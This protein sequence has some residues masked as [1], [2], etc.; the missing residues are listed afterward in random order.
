MIAVLEAHKANLFRRQFLAP[1]LIAGLIVGIV[2]LP[3]AMAFAIASG[4][5]PEAGLWTAIIAGFLISLLGGSSVQIGGPAGAFIVIVYGIVQQFGVGGLIAATLI[6]GVLLF[7]MGLLRLGTLVRFIPIAVIIGFTNGIAVLIGL[8]QVKDFL[9][10]SIEKMPGDFF[11]ILGALW[12]QLHTFNP[13]AL[14]VALASLI[15]IAV[16][17]QGMPALGA[18]APFSGRLNRVPGSIVALVLATTAVG[19]FKL[20]V[21][22]IGSRFGGVPSTLPSP[23][24]PTVTW[25]RIRE[26]FQ[27]AFTIAFLAGVESLLSAMV[28]DGMTGRRHR[29]NCELVAQGV[30]N[31]AS[32]L[33]GGISATGAI[34]R[35]AT[36]IRAG[37]RTPVAG[38]MHALF[39]LASMLALGPLMAYVPLA[40]LAAVL[41]IVAWNMSEH[42]RFRHLLGGPVGDRIVLLAT[43]GLTVLVDLTVAI[44]VGIVLAAII[45]MH[46]M[47]E[48]TAIQKGVS[49]V[50]KDRDDFSDPARTAYR[51]RRDLPKGVELFEFIRGDIAELK[52]RLFDPQSHS[53]IMAGMEA[54][55]WL[56]DHLDEWLGENHAGASAQAKVTA[57]WTNRL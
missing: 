25:E 6:S 17:Q 39:I 28:A 43:F 35:T 11:G 32:G 46:R 56:N 40:S 45:F 22:T 33:F 2:A 14:G 7:V 21:E 37:G 15:V 23:I 4:L 27:P 52:A 34:A 10:L 8:S 5:K 36:N 26:L 19:V 55:W 13:W 49:L 44:E 20:P 48:A 18:R 57:Y 53:V 30:A 29:S 51:A 38:M 3:L 16:W 41:V 54:T 31:V 12:G 42:E 1:N 9:G 24:I 47:A 50:E